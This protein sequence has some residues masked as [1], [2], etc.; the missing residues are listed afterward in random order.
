MT[1]QLPT[2]IGLPALKLKKAGFKAT[3]FFCFEKNDG[4]MALTPCTAGDK[5]IQK[6]QK[7]KI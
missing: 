3:Y 7:K 1:K 5:A 4:K 2:M 6:N